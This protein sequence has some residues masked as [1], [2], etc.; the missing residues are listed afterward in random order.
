MCAHVKV[1]RSS[2]SPDKRSGVPAGQDKVPAGRDKMPDRVLTLSCPRSAAARVSQSACNSVIASETWRSAVYF[3]QPSETADCR[4]A[5]LL[6]KTE[7]FVIATEP[8]S[9]VGSSTHAASA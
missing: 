5:S 6:A 2:I 3:Y 4:I 9:C 8:T 1:T 7:I